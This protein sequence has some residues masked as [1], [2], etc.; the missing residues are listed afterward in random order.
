MSTALSLLCSSLLTRLTLSLMLCSCIAGQ[1]TAA[2]QED[3]GPT[4]HALSWSGNHA[5]KDGELA[6]YILTEAPSWR[7]WKPTEP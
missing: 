2:G 7:W 3:S 4:V 5:L 6:D 1:A